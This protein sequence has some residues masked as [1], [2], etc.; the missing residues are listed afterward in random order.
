MKI[1]A[2]IGTAFL[3]FL[4]STNA[5]SNTSERNLT[6]Y[7]T[8]QNNQTIADPYTSRNLDMNDSGRFIFASGPGQNTGS[9]AGVAITYTDMALKVSQ[10][11]ESPE[12]DA[13]IEDEPNVDVSPDGQYMILRPNQNAE[14][15]YSS[16]AAPLY[17][18][19]VVNKT[20]EPIIK[21]H[22]GSPLTGCSAQWS[23]HNRSRSSFA[24][25]RNEVVYFSDCDNI[26]PNDV[27]GVSDLFVYDIKTG[28]NTLLT[29]IVAEDGSL[30]QANGS[31][32]SPEVDDSGRFV[33]FA[34][35]ADNF[36]EGACPTTT[37]FRT[38]V[39]DRQDGSYTRLNPCRESQAAASGLGYG[40]SAD[41]STIAINGNGTTS[42][43]PPIVAKRMRIYNPL[44]KTQQSFTSFYRNGQISMSY[45]G[46]IFAFISSAFYNADGSVEDVS[47]FGSQAVWNRNSD[48]YNTYANDFFTGLSVD[49][50]HH[51]ENMIS[52]GGDSVFFAGNSPR[53][54]S[55]N[56][57][58]E[59]SY[60]QSI[61]NNFVRNFSYITV[62]GTHNG[63]TSLSNMRHVDNNLWHAEI[64]VTE[65]NARFKFDVAGDWSENYGDN[66]NDGIGDASG[67][68]ILIN[69]GPGVYFITFNDSTR[70]YSVSQRQQLDFDSHLQGSDVSIHF[71]CA[72][73]ITS[74]GQS[75]Y[76]VGD[77]RALGL[78][79]PA[80]AILLNADNYP[81]WEGDIDI[82]A[83]TDVEWKCIKRSETDPTD[84]LIWQN[85]GNNLFNSADTIISTGQF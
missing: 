83:N 85:S 15:L 65:E 69:D 16:D 58:G 25:W 27:N 26:V 67:N 13:I 34:S 48:S 57:T 63:W 55:E 53:F 52:A 8:D 33:V 24:Y 23:L 42:P 56:I 12:F 20:L 79:D 31:S 4:T 44:T 10:Y 22:D 18:Y 35:N 41:G 45:D 61:D 11:V 17:L 84:Q 37:R 82:P 32:V 28:Q 74:V 30:S 64:V 29:Q 7:T 47:A 71:S 80:N 19:H 66:N 54:W 75:V 68:D 14:G 70:A 1:P 76:A 38:F 9:P 49:T 21:S 43:T 6:L 5:I 72:N 59:N 2:V 3:S 39:L 73:G 60:H 51:D 46:S 81:L 77:I 36:T 40:I 50:F 78:W 62:R